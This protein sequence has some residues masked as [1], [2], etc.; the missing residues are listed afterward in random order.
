MT[1]RRYQPARS[2][3]GARMFQECRRFLGRPDRYGGRGHIC[4][5]LQSLAWQSVCFPI[6]GWKSE[7]LLL[8]RHLHRD[9]KAVWE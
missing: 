6:A 5:L 3:H 9:E 2:R 8:R 7:Q 4:P 1:A